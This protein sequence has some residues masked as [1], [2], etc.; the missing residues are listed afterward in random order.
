MLN[1]LK[2]ATR[3]SLIVGTLLI[4]LLGV[5]G[6]CVLNQV[7]QYSYDSALSTATSV[8]EGSAREVEL[9]LKNATA[10]VDQLSAL[11]I[12]QN[13]SGRESRTEVIDFMKTSLAH[14][15]FILGIWIVTEPNSFGGNDAQYV[16]TPNSD[17]TGRFSPYIVKQD[18]QILSQ[19]SADYQMDSTAPYYTIPKENKAMALI[20]PYT[21]NVDGK[22]IVMVSL[23]IPM[24]DQN[25]GFI[26][27]AGAD[28]DMAK[29]QEQVAAAKPM[30]GFSALVSEKNLIMAHGTKP[31]LIGKN[32]SSYDERSIEAL[33]TIATGKTFNYMAKAAG[34]SD[35]TLKVFAPLNVPGQKD[36]WA[37]VSV[38]READLLKDYFKLRNTLFLIIASILVLMVAVVAW[39][40]PRMLKPLGVMSEYLVQIGNLD[41]SAPVPASLSTQGGEIGS[42]VQSVTDMKNHLTVIVRDILVVGDQTVR[43]VIR[44]ETSIEDMNGHLQEISATTEELTAGMEEA[45]Q[46]AESVYESTDEMSKAVLSLANRAEIG[47][48]TASDI[49]GNADQISRKAA[50]AIRQAS[51]MYHS[52]QSRLSEAIADARN[53]HRIT[54]LSEAIL[55]ISV[56]TNLLALNAAIEAA[57]AGEAGRG[58]SVVADEIR[59]LAEQSKFTVGEIQQTAAVILSSVDSLSASSSDMLTFI[60]SKVMS[61]YTLLEGVG[62]EFAEGA[63]IFRDLSVELSA[64]SEQ[65]SA[66]VETVHNSAQTMSQHVTEGA[67]ASAAI[68]G[69]T[70]SIAMNAET[71]HREALETRVR[72]ESLNEILSQIQ[73]ESQHSE[74]TEVTEFSSFSMYNAS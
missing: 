37:F 43:G 8:S 69:A 53:V 57:R 65:L 9:N 30:G 67:E 23:A 70:G 39:M 21:E 60:E 15:D 11:F 46:G 56:Q 73:L 68:A 28:I 48:Q 47:A 63:K 16:G 44:L 13:S 71:L 58:F 61:D 4:V 6:F 3:I 35:Q 49:H 52:T 5:L 55:A 1:R 45:S 51:D 74:P 29:F 66:S 31:D 20:P 17:S 2:M 40:V 50:D 41:L 59:K 64:T 10:Y 7:S 26:G 62:T 18:S 12:S 42:L 22:D 33:K 32:L 38:I 24:Y 72:S 14:S 25:G 19:E 27:V 36:K 34:T 54:E